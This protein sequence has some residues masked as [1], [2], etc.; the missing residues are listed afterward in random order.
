MKRAVLPLAVLLGIALLLTEVVWNR[1]DEAPGDPD[2]V[3]P[4]PAGTRPNE[5]PALKKQD[6]RALPHPAGV[7]DKRLRLRISIAGGT[8]RTRVEARTTLT[9]QGPDPFT[10]EQVVT[11]DD[12]GEALLDLAALLDRSKATELLLAVE[13]PRYLPIRVVLP[14]PSPA[15]IEGRLELHGRLIPALVVTGSVIGPDGRPAR[16]MAVGIYPVSAVPHPEDEGANHCWL[17]PTDRSFTGPDGRY[18]LRVET[19]ASYIIAVAE[20]DHLESFRA[21]PDATAVD[22]KGEGCEAPNLILREGVSLRGRLFLNELPFP[23]RNAWVHATLEGAPWSVGLLVGHGDMRWGRSGPVPSGQCD[24]VQAGAFHVQ[25]LAPGH[26][27]LE[28]GE[29]RTM[30]C[31]RA[32]LEAHAMVVEAPAD[33]VALHLRGVVVEVH[34][35]GAEGPIAGA[36]VTL[37]G[38][39]LD[40]TTTTDPLGVAKFLLRFDQAYTLAVEAAGYEGATREE[41]T[42]PKALQAAWRV[43]L[44]PK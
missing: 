15:P 1:R 3:R 11:L 38:S 6:R 7:A 9:P 17:E 33:D 20:S 19:P 5:A 28:V 22:V 42:P 30:G 37:M 32:L 24:K 25:N 14:I 18:A 12:E 40:P 2:G 27:V 26:W 10:D 39:G 8:P 34:V 16:N 43:F 4:Q 31:D 35:R 23:G 36:A 44:R 21:R 13:H 29:P 41:R